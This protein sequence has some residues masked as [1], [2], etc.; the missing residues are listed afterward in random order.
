MSGE[1]KE[2][3]PWKKITFNLP[4]LFSIAFN[5]PEYVNCG[6]SDRSGCT[7]SVCLYVSVPE[8]LSEPVPLIHH[9][10]G[11]QAAV[12]CISL[13][14]P[15]FWPGKSFPIILVYNT[16]LVIQLTHSIEHTTTKLIITL[17]HSERVWL[18]WSRP[19]GDGGHWENE[20]ERESEM[21]RE[22]K[23]ESRS[24]WLHAIK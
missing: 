15:W 19:R 22:V 12:L 21:E 18:Y 16:H 3:D 10:T 17:M 9:P 7:S 14:T 24:H 13:F 6:H 1:E 8:G 23:R 11:T 2:I 5:F 20:R 4:T